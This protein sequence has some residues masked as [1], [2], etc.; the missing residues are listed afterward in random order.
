MS[1]PT[2]LSAV[3]ATLAGTALG[4]LSGC[5]PALHVA[6]VLSV[7]ALTGH[8]LLAGGVSLPA[9]VV[10]AFTAAAVTAWSLAN[11]IPAILLAAPDESALFT[12]L[13]GQ[14]SLMRG[15]GYEAVMTTAAGGAAGMV[16]LLLAAP[17]LPR[18]LPEVHPVL[19]P[20]YHWI[21]W[22]VIA[23]M[24]MS[25]WAPGPVSGQG[26][27]RRFAAAWR[28]VVWGL[29]T[30]LLSGLLGFLLYYRS[31]VALGVSFQGLLPAFAGLFA[32]PGLILNLVARVRIPPQHVAASLD[33]DAPALLHGVGAGVLGGGMAAFLPV[34]T[35]GV[36]GFLAGH[37]VSV[38]NDRVF[39]VAQGASKA[40]YY[41]GGFLLLF[42]PGLG[43]VRGG[44]AR[45]CRGLCAPAPA[46]DYP[47]ALFA[48]A[49][50]AALTLLA[51]PLATRAS[52]RFAE[53]VGYRPL[54]A[55]ALAA[56]VGLV[57]ALTGLPGAG[58]LAVATG[59]GLLPVV[60]GSRRL[61][62]LGVI[63]LPTACNM[64]G[65]GTRVAGWLGLL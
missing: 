59:I 64:S 41:A 29:A 32:L 61:N 60:S 34:V 22:T 5:I 52:L 21:L 30:F 11:S 8:T 46:R 45:L 15:R 24:L 56:V 49:S 17:L 55:A 48:I 39:L 31:P 1:D 62:C 47:V 53:R 4:F 35:G 20:H 50:A 26:G 16:A 18:V 3:L 36:G 10:P 44:A 6:N 12:V 27:W 9:A 65:F 2:L 42:V 37:A 23:F 25:E 7:A 19:R 13:P 40:L 51:L 43:L 54:S 63:L 33:L 14:E 58:L 28:S 38:R 57:M